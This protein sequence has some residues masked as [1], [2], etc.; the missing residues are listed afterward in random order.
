MSTKTTRAACGVRVVASTL[1]TEEA[2][3]AARA[4]LADG[5][6]QHIIVFFSIKHDP[7]VLLK[8]LQQNFPDVTVSGC[9][10]AGEVGPLGMTQGGI[11]FIAFPEKG[12]RV[13]SEVIPDIDKGGVERASEIARRLRV[14]MITGVSRA[15]KENIFALV[16]VDGLSDREEPLTA[17]LHWSLEDMELLGG[18]AGDG[19][20]FQRT[21]LIHRGKLIRRGAI[22]FVI[23]T[24][25]PF[26]VFK[27]QNFEPTPIKLVVTAADSEHRIVYDLNAEP[28]A[29]EYASA[30]GVSLDDLGPLSFATYP[31][32][33]KVG[34]EY[35]GRAIR[36]MN[37]DG[38]LSFLCAIDEGLV[39]TVGRPRDMVQSTLE[40]LKQVDAALGGIDF[41]LGFDCFLRRIDAETGQLR[42]KV[43]EIY[44]RYGLAG[45]QTY[46]EQFNAMHLNQTLTGI[47]FS[48]PHGRI[49]PP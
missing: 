20:A 18:S 45:F 28:A 25:T 43:E 11:V 47:A 49:E 30:I 15:A 32:V 7:E 27:T 34:G 19:L 17:A 4:E 1:S 24:S 16:L 29:S 33:V 31:L 22:L 44:D 48:K 9:S 5:V 41:V 26:R 21:A 40:T 23:E 38:S 10:T 13:M 14:Q 2:V 8:A 39:F 12:F 36:N 6:F 46:G 3:S 37:P 42:H 35:Y